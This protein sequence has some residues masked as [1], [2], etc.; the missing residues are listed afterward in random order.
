MQETKLHLP[1]IYTSTTL[2]STNQTLR[3]ESPN[4]SDS[5]E[6]RRDSNQEI[7]QNPLPETD[8]LPKDLQIEHQG[9]Y[10]TNRETECRSHERHNA[11][12]RWENDAN[13]DKNNNYNNSNYYFQDASGVARE[14]C[15]S[16]RIGNGN[17]VES[18]EYFDGG[19][20]WACVEWD[21]GERNDGDEDTHQDRECS[22][23][24]GGIDYVCSD[25]VHDAV[26]EH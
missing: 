20:D 8:L 9:Q 7:T 24:A 6:H 14:A 13:N 19:D 10:N 26:A 16:W 25:L 1:Y 12:K 21:F 11:I 2:F 4:C 5:R 3:Q 23:I 22:W 18:G 15:E 17:W